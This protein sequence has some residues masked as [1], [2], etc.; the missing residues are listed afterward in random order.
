M[1]NELPKYFKQIEINLSLVTI[2]GKNIF[3]PTFSLIILVVT[4]SFIQYILMLKKSTKFLRKINFKFVKIS[5]NIIFFDPNYQT[6]YLT[7]DSSLYRQEIKMNQFTVVSNSNFN[8]KMYYLLSFYS[9]AGFS[10]PRIVCNSRFY[11]S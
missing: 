9:M 2:P 11:V 10:R 5:G 8:S 3:V 4:L 7:T 6:N 1:G